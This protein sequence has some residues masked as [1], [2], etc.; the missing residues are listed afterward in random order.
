V[1]TVQELGLGEGEWELVFAIGWTQ[2]L[3][4]SWDELVG[5]RAPQSEGYELTRKRVRIASHL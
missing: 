1:T 2:A 4:T 3:P 5:E